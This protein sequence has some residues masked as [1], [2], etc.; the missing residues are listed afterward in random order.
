MARPSKRVWGWMFF[1]WA[2]QPFFTLMLT[3]IFGPYFASAVMDD[4]ATGQEYWGWMLAAV[5]I[6]IA[7]LAPI[8]GSIADGS[9][10]RMNWVAAFSLVHMVGVLCLWW[11]IPDS[12]DWILILAAFGLAMIAVEFA[13]IFTN[14]M[15]PSLGPRSD[16][17]VISGSGWAFGYAGGIVALLLALL[18]LAENETG[19]TLL[20][21][22]PA[23]GL[24]PEMREGTRATGVFTAIW[25]AVFMIPFF[26]WVKET[27]D[28][29]SDR[30]A[31]SGL[32]KTLR[33]LP[34]QPS[35]LAYLGSSMFYRDALN[36]LYAF[37]GIYATGVLGWSIVQIGAFGIAS[38]VSGCIFAWLGGFADRRF[39]PKP[40]I[41]FC[42]ALLSLVCAII[43]STSDDTVIMLPVGSDSALPDITFFLCGCLI[44]AGGGVLQ[45][46]S[47]TMMVVQANPDRMTEAFGLYAFAGRATA[48]AAPALIAT[49]TALTGDQR[50]GVA[51]I[52]LL[53]VIG[54]LL[55]RWV[56]PHGSKQGAHST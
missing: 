7:V 29:P 10:S 43:I 31:V 18:F 8:L 26:L 11:A 44:G 46:V 16:V 21:T 40:V 24:D 1:D 15:L 56:S 53:F 3:F 48:F 20:G 17:G 37:G 4:P 19:K 30:Q 2:S 25:F 32:V 41:N 54:L 34:S 6:L 13:T 38:L 45:A 36:G 23:F 33:R 47:R 49:T 9:G 51:P 55:M 27:Q 39:G 14:A 28:S 42:I 5:G 35:L 50:I 22:S 12:P 52:L